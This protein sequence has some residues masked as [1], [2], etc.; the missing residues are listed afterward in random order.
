[1]GQANSAGWMLGVGYYGGKGQPLRNVVVN[2]NSIGCI[3]M[4]DVVIKKIPI[5]VLLLFCGLLLSGVFLP[6]YSDEVVTKF[7]IARLFLERGDAV[8]LFPQCTA[9]AGRTVSWIFY[10][11][12]M[13]L[14]ALYAHLEPLGLRVSGIVLSLIWFVLL[15]YWC[16]AQTRDSGV[17]LQ[18]FA[19][20]VAVG[21]LGILPFLWVLSRPEQL[22]ILAILM[23]SLAALF[24]SK[25]T[26]AKG[27]ASVTAGMALLLS[28]LFYAHPKSMFYMPFALVAVWLAT[29]SYHKV[30][31]YGLILF[32]LGSCVQVFHY[33]NALGNCQ[34]APGI[35]LMLGANTLLPGALLSAPDEFISA[36]FNNF[37]RFPDRLLTHLTFNETYQ[38]GW[39]PPLS[40][41]FEALPYLNLAIYY[42][43]FI[44]VAGVHF[45][46]VSLFL[47]QL[48]H[49]RVTGPVLLALLLV[50]ANVVN[51]FFYNIQNF[52]AG[53]Q[54]IPV[55]IIIT[56]LLMQ[57]RRGVKGN[58]APAL[59]AYS[60]LLLF[61][62]VSMVTSLALVTPGITR[63]ISSAQSSLSGQPLS[64]PVFGVQSHL[65]SIRKLGASC[66]I[67]T[68][69]TA[70]VV[71]DHMTYFAFVQDKKPIHVLYVT[72]FGYGGDL[73]NGR[74][75]PFLKG[76]NSPGLIT[77]C[78]WVPNEF[79]QAQQTGEMGYCCVNFSKM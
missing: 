44:F 23:L 47:L 56:A 67:P 11:I 38:S 66:E 22:L 13:L 57:S 25:P 51:A 43:L 31:R 3:V 69:S 59:V 55:T 62:I 5:V 2:F 37:I 29:A 28:F 35:K 64:I 76:L 77:R 61:S 34:D 17:A 7:R 42:F 9:T 19:G 40:G 78:E 18:R 39:L 72:E 68:A 6:V 21:S 49:R 12:G 54:F 15:A 73:T 48:I 26:S 36:A 1:M 58:S 14:S 30:I 8:T 74:L 60:L 52:Y 75:L 16:W 41:S 10:P 4:R 45:L 50:G 70:S 79:R 63:N 71:V 24:S 46:A 27:Q 20:F 33:F 32:V 65:D 53:T